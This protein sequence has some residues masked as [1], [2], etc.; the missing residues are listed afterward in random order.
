[1]KCDLCG[2]KIA[3]QLVSYTLFYEGQWIIVDHVP[4]NVCLQCG[5][6]LFEPGTVEHLQKIIW[7]HHKPAKKIETPVYE[8]A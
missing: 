3:R 2:G 8:Y 7:E 4:A 5:E 6:K 1:M